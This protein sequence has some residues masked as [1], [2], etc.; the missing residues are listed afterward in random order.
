MKGPKSCNNWDSGFKFRVY[1]VCYLR[2]YFRFILLYFYI[3]CCLSTIWP[4]GRL[5]NWQQNGEITFIRIQMEHK[6]RSI[7]REGLDFSDLTLYSNHLPPPPFLNRLTNRT[8]ITFEWSRDAQPL[9]WLS[10]SK[11][12]CII[13]QQ[14]WI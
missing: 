7:N 13:L 4:L 10:N 5:L 14:L 8:L 12:V 6:F 3:Y 11:G 9:L 1:E 2:I